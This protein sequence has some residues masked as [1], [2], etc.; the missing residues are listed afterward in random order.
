MPVSQQ[1]AACSRVR[2]A[3]ERRDYGRALGMLRDAMVM[4]VR[5]AAR[6]GVLCHGSPE[7]DA[8]C[9]E[10]GHAMA[11]EA[12]A[13]GQPR[14]P[15]DL[16]VASELYATGGHT[17]LLGDYLRASDRRR[18]L[19]V[20][21]LLNGPRR[22]PEAVRNR[23]DLAPGEVLLCQEPDPDG[24]CR[25]LIDL[26][27]LHRPQR[28]FLFTHSHDSAA[29]A[30]CVPADGIRHHFIHHADHSPAL[31]AFRTDFL[32]I[33]L[34]PFCFACCAPAHGAGNRFLSV[35]AKD[36]G[37]RP[38]AEFAARRPPLLTAACGSSS[39]FELGRSTLY[40]Q[41]VATILKTTGGRH[42]H[43]G[44]L[45]PAQLRGIRRILRRHGA[46]IGQFE[47]VPFVPSLW[48]ALG[49]RKVDL[50]VGSL[51]QRGARASVEAMGS[52]TPA[53]W[54]VASEETRFHD[55]HM[56]YPEAASWHDQGE[57]A[58]LLA[59]IDGAWLARQSAASRAQF[60]LRHDPRILGRRLAMADLDAP[61][62]ALPEG[63]P[64]RPPVVA[65]GTLPISFQDRL[66]ARLVAARTAWRA[67]GSR[68]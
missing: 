13:A 44:D 50:Y 33:D 62:P 55:T 42:L 31:G 35:T 14:Q 59:G 6:A 54:Y 60:E 9:R 36:L 24:K 20:T 27:R 43:I 40:G 65:F 30:A 7:M 25:W 19:A 2:E 23:L 57:L 52:G 34:T 11:G 26:I 17:G 18:L 1:A 5:A 32:H 41:S 37:P 51:P 58:A 46:A 66:Y 21:R 63:N 64:G 56:K 29:V 10:I 39:K 4:G 48:H 67:L 3:L 16:F 38:A 22:L 45:S 28:V 68:S 15:L 8:L 49:E 47:H 53:I 61:A 12:A